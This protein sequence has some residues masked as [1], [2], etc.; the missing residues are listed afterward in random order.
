MSLGFSDCS[1]LTGLSDEGG[2][3]GFDDGEQGRPHG[4]VEH[5]HGAM[6]RTPGLTNV[7]VQSAKPPRPRQLV[8]MC[9]V[10]DVLRKARPRS[11]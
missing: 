3:N 5:R 2:P 4:L 9:R 10:S 11:L 7:V 8:V 6:W 1:M